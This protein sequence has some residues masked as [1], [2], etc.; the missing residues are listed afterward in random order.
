MDLLSSSDKLTNFSLLPRLACRKIS[1][2]QS[3][4]WPRDVE[5][6]LALVTLLGVWTKEV[7]DEEFAEA[8]GGWGGGK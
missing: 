3:G 1:L 8:G 2:I 4:V 7:E 5:V 6:V